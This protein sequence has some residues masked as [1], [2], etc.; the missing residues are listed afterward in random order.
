MIDKEIAEWLKRYTD[1]YGVPKADKCAK[2]HSDPKLEV[3]SEKGCG[4]GRL[5]CS[6]PS[7]GNSCFGATSEDSE[8]LIRS[9]VANWNKRQMK[10]FKEKA[11]KSTKKK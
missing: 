11:K 1:K 7:C 4:T 6:N 8:E 10:I 5:V 2:C 3:E 9:S